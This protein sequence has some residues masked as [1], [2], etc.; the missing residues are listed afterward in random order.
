MVL[1]NKLSQCFQQCQADL[2]HSHDKLLLVGDKLNQSRLLASRLKKKCMQAAEK[3]ERAVKKAW[4]EVLKEKSVH[5]LHHKGVYT[6]DTWHIVRL[7]VKAG[8]SRGLVSDI[9]C[10]VLKSAGMTT[11]GK[12]SRSTVSQIITEGYFAAQIQLGYELLNAESMC[13][14]SF[15]N[16]PHID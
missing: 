9:I 8:C 1:Q 2:K 11:I 7:L 6:E 4:D 10:A 3:Q 13:F 5:K 16:T 15:Y 14:I 12:I